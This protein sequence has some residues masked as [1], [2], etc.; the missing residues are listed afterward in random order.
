MKE[1]NLISRRDLLARGF[2]T[3]AAVG[4]GAVALGALGDF[5]PL[6][7]KALANLSADDLD[8]VSSDP[9]VLTCSATLGP[10][11]YNTGLVRRDITETSNGKAGLP[12]R[13]GFRI[14]N[15]DTCEP[16]TNAS[17]DI[18]HTDNQGIYS[19]PISAF[20]NGSG[21]AGTTAQSQRFGRGL[22]NTDSNGWAYFDTFYPGWYSSRVTH[23]HATIRIGTTAIVTTQFFFLDRVSEFIY[24]SHPNYSNRPNRD[25]TNLTDNV[26][27]GQ[28]LA[29]VLPYVFSTK[30]VNNKYLQATKTIGIRTTPTSCN[31]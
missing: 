27:G 16:I 2:K 15:A 24:R 28:G 18:W 7:S 9:C 29:R 14:V 22:Q 31:A 12:T 19:A 1:N 26:I 30:L 20:C 11:Y 5:S 23:I 13:L 25:T 17:I 21:T 3:A 6:S 10:C 8:F 4:L